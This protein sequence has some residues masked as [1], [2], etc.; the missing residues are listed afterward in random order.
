LKRQASLSDH[1]EKGDREEK[2][3]TRRR[4][5]KE[6]KFVEVKNDSDDSLMGG[7]LSSDDDFEIKAPK[8]EDYKPEPV[9]EKKK[10]APKRKG[11]KPRKAKQN[12]LKLRNK[13]LGDV[14]VMDEPKIGGTFKDDDGFDPYEETR[15]QEIIEGNLDFNV[16][17][18]GS[19]SQKKPT[20]NFK[21]DFKNRG[22][23]T[24]IVKGL[25]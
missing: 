17:D 12:G 13:L 8:E 14:N 16:D 6:T 22:E 21:L 2:V 5:N 19:Y 23:E 25:W 10:A 3:V 1:S 24:G 9:K 15:P 4:S 20:S 11:G 7:D 18:D